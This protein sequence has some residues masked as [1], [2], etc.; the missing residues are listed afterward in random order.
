MILF[1]YCF[2]FLAEMLESTLQ[3]RTTQTDFLL[4]AKSDLS[5]QFSTEGCQERDVN[6]SLSLESNYSSFTLKWGKR[7][8]KVRLGF[9][10]S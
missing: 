9:T 7:L 5:V 8:P 3:L 6:F 2:I 10:F 4:T 1:G